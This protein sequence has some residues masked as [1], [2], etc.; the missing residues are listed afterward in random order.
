MTEQGS[1]GVTPRVLELQRL[2]DATTRLM[3]HAPTGRIDLG[4]TQSYH[5]A[6]LAL[7]NLRDELRRS[8]AVT[9]DESYW[10]TD[11]A[12]VRES[13]ASVPAANVQELDRWRVFYRALAWMVNDYIGVCGISADFTQKD[14]R[15]GYA[16]EGYHNARRLMHGQKPPIPERL[17]R[18]NEE[19]ACLVGGNQ[20]P[21]RCVCQEKETG[22]FAGTPHKHYDEPPYECARCECKSYRPAVPAAS[23]DQKHGR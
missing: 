7:T 2:Y 14:G 5:D 21:D 20:H 1:A 16:H 13:V 9:H 10:E 15:L 17:R 8:G 6:M 23:E 18:F 12:V 22:Q 4:A 11:K 3:S 19:T